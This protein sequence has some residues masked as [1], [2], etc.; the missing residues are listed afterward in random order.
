M[1]LVAGRIVI[2]LTELLLRHCFE[3]LQMSGVM[4]PAKL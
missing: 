1:P 3:P 2:K 4:G